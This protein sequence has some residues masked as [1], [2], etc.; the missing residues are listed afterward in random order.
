MTS[1]KEVPASAGMTNMRGI[2][3]IPASAGI[4]VRYTY[5]PE[6]KC[7]VIYD[8]IKQQNIF[9]S[10]KIAIPEMHREKK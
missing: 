2:K 3:E 9:S 4:A 8:S 5:C 10:H 1:L 7:S 6:F